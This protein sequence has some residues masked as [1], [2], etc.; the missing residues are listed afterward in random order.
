[1]FQCG[2]LCCEHILH[3]VPFSTRFSFLE[4]AKGCEPIY[5]SLLSHWLV[6]LIPFVIP[7]RRNLAVFPLPLM[8]LDL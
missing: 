2:R 4:Y 8:E 5:F 6:L 3:G 1:M 7:I